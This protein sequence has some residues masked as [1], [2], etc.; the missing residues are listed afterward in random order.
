MTEFELNT[1][2]RVRNI[3]LAMNFMRGVVGYEDLNVV[4]EDLQ[5]TQWLLNEL[6]E[7]VKKEI[8]I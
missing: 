6:V 5:S 1:E 2:D 4:L 7:D 3:E 8:I